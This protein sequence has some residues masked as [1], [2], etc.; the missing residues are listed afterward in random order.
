MNPSSGT[1]KRHN[2]HHRGRDGIM[3]FLWKLSRIGERLSP[4]IGLGCFIM[5]INILFLK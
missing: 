2:H 4:Y 3:G 5:S 1:M